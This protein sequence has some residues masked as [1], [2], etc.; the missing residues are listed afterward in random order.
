MGVGGVMNA[1]TVDAARSLGSSAQPTVLDFL[2]A[3]DALSVAAGAE[4]GLGGFHI[5]QFAQIARELRIA[6]I[7]DLI[8]HGCIPAVQMPDRKRAGGFVARA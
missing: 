3:I 7:G 8:R 1:L 6:K 2:V 4:P 5:P